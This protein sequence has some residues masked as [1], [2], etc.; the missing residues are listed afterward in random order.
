MR[1]ILA[2]FLASRLLFLLFALLAPLFTPLREGYLGTQFD[3]AAPY[4]AWVWANFD[5]RHFLSIATEGYQRTNFAYFPLYP[6][7]IWL[8]GRISIIPPL[9]LGILISGFL[10][11]AS[12]FVLHKIIRLDYKDNTASLAL[13]F[14]CLFPLSFFYHS[15]YA[16]SLFL[17]L[18]TSSFYFARKGNWPASGILGAL[19]V[20]TRLSG[21]ALI[22]AL[23]LEWYLQNKKLKARGFI[24][25]FLTLLGLVIYMVYLKLNFGDPLLFQKSMS[26]WQ[27]SSFVF[28]PQVIWRYLKIFFFVDKNLLV[29]WIAVLEFASLFAYL[30]LSVYVWKKIRASYGA[31]MVALLLLISF[32]G[33]FAGTPRYLLHLFPA[34]TGMA[35]LM[36]KNRPLLIITVTVFLLFGFILTALFTRGYFVA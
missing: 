1:K 24:A 22:P 14:L 5:G 2:Y 19:T 15:V 8:L 21:V 31:F 26:A 3:R 16:D 12:M 28:P 35:L 13:F 4:L 9:Y 6:A 23:I 32:T 11:L 34:Y 30:A 33:T 7:A 18:S 29:F 25:P 20:L 10:F 17:L 27:Q 36:H